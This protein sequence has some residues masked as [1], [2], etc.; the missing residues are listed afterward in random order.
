MVGGVAGRAGEM[1]DPG[2]ESGGAWARPSW[3]EPADDAPRQ[4]PLTPGPYGPPPPGAPSYPPYG[5]PPYGPPPA[6]APP[7]GAPPYGPPPYG[8]PPAP[9]PGVVPLRP[10]GLGELLDGALTTVRRYP[11]LTLGLAALVLTVQQL[12]GVL[13]QLAGGLAPSLPASPGLG[14]SLSG[15]FGSALASTFTGAAVVLFALQFVV[16]AVLGV[17]LTGMLVV[18]V[19]EAVLGRPIGLAQLWD[20][21]RPRFWALLGASVLAELLPW[22]GLVLAA[23]VGVAIGLAFGSTP[24]IVVGVLLGVVLLVFPGIP[25]WT[26]YSLTAPALVL[27][28]LGPMAA[29]RRSWRLVLPGFWRVLGIRLLSLVI[30][31]IISQIVLVP[32][33]IVVGVVAFGGSGGTGEPTG[34]LRLVVVLVSALGGVVAG[35]I[36]Q[37]FVAGVVALLYVDRRM[38]GEGLDIAL[39]ETALGGSPRS[40]SDA[41]GAAGQPGW[42][43]AT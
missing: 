13:A 2:E 35:T 7:Y 5:A 12:I 4:G 9:K 34:A 27:E 8:P 41:P 30:A 21:V 18:V 1:T 40:G 25:L 10:L 37:P 11:R 28:R 42:G 29:L 19:A 31:G 36:T 17:V 32:F 33:L 6:G 16:A 39:Q 14:G 22:A 3:G 24:G 20:R 43:P 23:L 38:R 15:S 26:L